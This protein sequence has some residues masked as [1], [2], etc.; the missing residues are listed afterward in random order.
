MALAHRYGML[1]M[2]KTQQESLPNASLNKG[3]PDPPLFQD[4]R[5]YKNS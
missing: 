4:R 5:Q 1:T 2:G 3:D